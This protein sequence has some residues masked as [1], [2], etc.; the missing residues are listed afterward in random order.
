MLDEKALRDRGP[1]LRS[2]S[3]QNRRLPG[4]S[5]YYALAGELTSQ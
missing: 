5:Y 2:V 4:S 3:S 1:Q